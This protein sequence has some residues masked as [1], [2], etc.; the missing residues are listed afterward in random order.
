MEITMTLSKKAAQLVQYAIFRTY[1]SIGD[2]IDK[3]LILNNPLH[4]SM[5]DACH[6]EALLALDIYDQLDT[7]F[8]ST[9]I[10]EVKA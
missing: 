1:I 9:K 5:L 4:M 7:C 6:K 10:R 3:G 8:N 2:T